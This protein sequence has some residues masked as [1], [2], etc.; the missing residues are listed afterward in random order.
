MSFLVGHDEVDRPSGLQ[1]N[2]TCLSSSV[3]KRDATL[4]ARR[5]A[6]TCGA[7]QVA[8]QRETGHTQRP[9]QDTG[10]LSRSCSTLLSRGDAQTGSVSS[11][12]QVELGDS[13]GSLF[14]VWWRGLDLAMD[15]L[16]I[17]EEWNRRTSF[18]ARART[19]TSEVGRAHIYSHILSGRGGTSL[20]VSDRGPRTRNGKLKSRPPQDVLAAEFAKWQPL[21]LEQRERKWSRS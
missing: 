6:S 13:E 3:C 21:W 2:A 4:N 15:Q 1:S 17:E 10:G 8:R 18:F 19:A 14:M 12:G 9:K 7:T 11:T 5:W 16:R 20:A